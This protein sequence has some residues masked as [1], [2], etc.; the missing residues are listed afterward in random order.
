MPFN[1][2]ASL[3]IINMYKRIDYLHIFI[4]SC[5]R[6]VKYLL[7]ISTHKYVKVRILFLYKCAI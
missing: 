6:L 5:N 1:L 4:F 2:L 3:L 7:L